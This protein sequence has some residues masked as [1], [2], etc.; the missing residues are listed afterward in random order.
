MNSEAVFSAAFFSSELAPLPLMK[1]ERK[2]YRGIFY[3]DKKLSQVPFGRVE[4]PSLPDKRCQITNDHWI[5]SML[6]VMAER[7]QLPFCL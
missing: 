4:G 6:V 3:P 2:G 7:E 5:S 1:I